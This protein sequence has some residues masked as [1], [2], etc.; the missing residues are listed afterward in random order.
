MN[1]CFY[2]GHS[3]KVFQSHV[4]LSQNRHQYPWGLYT[5]VEFPMKKCAFRVAPF[6]LYDEL[7]NK[8]SGIWILLWY[9]DFQRPKKL[10]RISKTLYTNQWLS[11]FFLTFLIL[12]LIGAWLAGGCEVF[13]F[14][15]EFWEKSM[16]TSN[17][18]ASFWS[19]NQTLC[20]PGKKNEQRLSSI[21]KAQVRHASPCFVKLDPT[22]AAKLQL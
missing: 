22:P 5:R 15:R 2:I 16:T 13:T 21:E 14:T 6:P 10:K 1:H 4:E 8:W 7:I 12:S 17:E 20:I 19:V 18:A 9:F 3:S 11:N